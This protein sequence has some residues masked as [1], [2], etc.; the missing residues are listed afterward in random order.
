MVEITV[1]ARSRAR[2]ESHTVDIPE[3]N[4]LFNAVPRPVTPIPDV[5]AAVEGVLDTPLESRRIEQIA[6]SDSKV[7]IAVTHMPVQPQHIIVPAIINRLETTGVKTENIK[8][9]LGQGVHW[10][11]S[12]APRNALARR[13]TKRVADDF[14]IIPHTGRP[15][16][17]AK[18]GPGGAL[19][20][21][22]F[23]SYGTPLFINREFA[24]CDVKISV[25]HIVYN[26]LT[27][28]RGGGKM[29]IPGVAGWDTINHNHR[30][31]L[32]REA[33]WDSMNLV[34]NVFAPP[35]LDTE[36]AARIVG[37]N[38][39]LDCVM[40]P[41]A[42]R[43]WGAQ[44]EGKVASINAGDQVAEHRKGAKVVDYMLKY[45]I[46][47]PADVMITRGWMRGYNTPLY[48][49]ALKKGGTVIALYPHW[50]DHPNVHEG[51]PYWKSCEKE[52]HLAKFSWPREKLIQDIFR[53]GGSGVGCPGWIAC[54]VYPGNRFLQEKKMTIVSKHGD[55]EVWEGSGI[56]YAYSLE[57]ALD[58]AYKNYGKD[59]KII[60]NRYGAWCIAPGEGVD[61]RKICS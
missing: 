38:F 9:F 39:V 18:G 47:R 40:I 58:E 21:K 31:T 26:P 33:G 49:T 45:Y 36:E 10:G 52:S 44:F 59:M 27:G 50:K 55:H 16:A 30:L 3:K 1:T 41:T 54:C 56:D 14:E 51:C 34:G 5:A 8:I 32:S 4:I 19:T 13:F 29:I 42:E 20:F 22:G 37:L 25:G 46:P 43:T 53:A 35:R 6:R 7:A 48:D 28:Y 61:R 23:T 60:V 17:E 15:E 57:E 11:S 12:H 2:V 24:K